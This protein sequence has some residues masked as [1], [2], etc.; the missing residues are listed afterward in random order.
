[1]FGKSKKIF[2][3][4]NCPECVGFNIQNFQ[5]MFPLSES[6]DKFQKSFIFLFFQVI[7]KF[8]QFQILFRC[9]KKYNFSKIFP[10]CNKCWRFRIW[11]FNNGRIVICVHKFRKCV[12]ISKD[13]PTFKI[14]TQIIIIFKICWQ[15]KK[16]VLVN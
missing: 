8:S 2:S 10:L 14:C 15:N 4:K 12:G 1:M 5:K 3:F 13:I 11:K 7:L 9:S 16:I 6:V